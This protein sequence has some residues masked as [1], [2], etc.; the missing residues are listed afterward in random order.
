MSEAQKVLPA[1]IE[2][3]QNSYEACTD[4]D[5]VVI[6][7]EWNQYRAL[8]IDR[9]AGLM[10]DKVFVDLRNVYS[11]ESITERGFRYTGVGRS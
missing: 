6:M 2:Y 5:A 3:V 4:A 11:P 7:T 10:R 1:S 9:L 8:D